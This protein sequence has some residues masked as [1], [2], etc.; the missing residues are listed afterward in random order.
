MLRLLLDEH[1]SP[2]VARGLRQLN[3][4]LTVLAISEWKN[5]N[6]L[7]ADDLTCLQHAV[8]EGLTLVTY[9]L[10][11]IPP[12]LRRMA[13]ESEHHGGVIFVAEKT[14]PSG[15]IG[16]LIRGLQTLIETAADCDGVDRVWFLSRATD[17]E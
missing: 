6:F 7:G 15:N 2:K 3:P 11:T 12:I 16:A 13:E 5:G 10:R 8:L 17:M 14:I 4:G 9:D 1:I